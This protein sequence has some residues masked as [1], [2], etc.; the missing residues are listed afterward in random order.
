[1]LKKVWSYTVYFCIRLRTIRDNPTE[2]VLPHSPIGTTTITLPG[3]L[4]SLGNLILI[5]IKVVSLIK[6]I[7]TVHNI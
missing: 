7:R 6:V 3:S 1:M 2:R 5:V 4:A